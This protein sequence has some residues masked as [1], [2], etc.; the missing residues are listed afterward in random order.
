MK[1]ATTVLAAPCEWRQ[2]FRKTECVVVSALQRQV[3]EDTLLNHRRL[4]EA[5]PAL[6]AAFRAAERFLGCP[7]DS[8]DGPAVTRAFLA[9]QE[10]IK[11]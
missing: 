11:A 1:W 10:A 3:I 9:A 2:T 8:P 7:V 4:M 5:A 6:L